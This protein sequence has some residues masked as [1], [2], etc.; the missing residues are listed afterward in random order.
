[1]NFENWYDLIDLFDVLNISKSNY[2]KYRGIK[3]Q[4]K[5]SSYRLFKT[6]CSFP[7]N[8]LGSSTNLSIQPSN[9]L[10][11]IASIK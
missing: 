6:S 4:T 11:L 1:M 7:S 8:S 10:F 5:K 2:Y 3:S 9:E